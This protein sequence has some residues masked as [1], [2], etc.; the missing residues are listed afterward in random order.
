[1]Q[2]KLEIK[3]VLFVFMFHAHYFNNKRRTYMHFTKR[4]N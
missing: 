2:I 4:I 1:M 3:I